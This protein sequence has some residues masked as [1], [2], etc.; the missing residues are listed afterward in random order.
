MQGWAPL[1][2]PSHCLRLS[3]LRVPAT[4]QETPEQLVEPAGS[5]AGPSGLCGIPGHESEK[6]HCDT[7]PV[8]YDF[9]GQAIA[10]TNP[11]A[12][13]PSRLWEMVKEA[14]SLWKPSLPPRDTP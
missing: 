3:L 11:H 12:K 9:W 4:R 14:K 13:V 10:M 5:L 1:A 2:R 7:N 6:L 8:N